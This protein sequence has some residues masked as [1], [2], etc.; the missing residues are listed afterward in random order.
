MSRK[1][2]EIYFFVFYLDFQREI[3]ILIRGHP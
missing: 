1:I 3:M 2:V